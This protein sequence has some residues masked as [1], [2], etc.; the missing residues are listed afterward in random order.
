MKM[1]GHCIV[2]VRLPC[3][4]FTQSLTLPWLAASLRLAHYLRVE[5][6]PMV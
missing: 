1:R 5:P 4:D 2:L 6:T 3:Y